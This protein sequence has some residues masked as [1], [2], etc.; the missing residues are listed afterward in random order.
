MT[1]DIGSPKQLSCPRRGPEGVV[2]A[3]G[4]P[5]AAFFG[6][7]KAARLLC[8]T[9]GGLSEAG[10]LPRQLVP[11]ARPVFREVIPEGRTGPLA[12][13]AVDATHTDD[14]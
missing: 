10:E 8:G 14:L 2:E 7:P 4:L 9:L 5:R 12:E 6:F 11:R 3:A 13:A 1:L